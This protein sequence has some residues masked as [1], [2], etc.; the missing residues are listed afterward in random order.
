MMSKRGGM[1]VAVMVALTLSSCATAAPETTALPSSTTVAVSTSST[2]EVPAT[3]TTQPSGDPAESVTEEAAMAFGAWID[4]VAAA[5]TD[6]A[7]DLMAQSSRDA[8]RSKEL[9]TSMGS[10]MSEGWGA[11]ATADSVTYGVTMDKAGRTILNV[12]GTV[13]QEGM[14]EHKSVGVP[15]EQIA[16]H[17]LLSPFQEFGT[18]AQGLQED[19][20]GKPQPPVPDNSGSGRRIVY[21][22]SGQRVW[23]VEADGTVFDTYLVSGKEG[24]PDPGTYE[25]Y[26]KSD[27]AYAGHD[28]IT[29]RD[30]VRFAHGDNLPIGFHAI[31]N[32]G[33]GRPLESED[34][35]GEY[36]SAG[37]VRQSIGHAAELYDWAE[38]GTAV[39]VLA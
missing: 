6:L 32:D 20:A 28:G 23:L 13:S 21:S 12:E 11:W 5:D 1:V 33:N 36:H 9:F 24:V 10:E 7:W 29:M 2:A 34:Q 31:P 39:I 35:L 14:T 25:V 22:N 30:M 38:V 18:V 27:M 17:V 3:T 8:I 15:I 19:A 16:G 4:A 26:S 37:C